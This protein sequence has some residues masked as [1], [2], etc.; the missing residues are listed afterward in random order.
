MANSPDT[1]LSGSN[2]D[3]IEG[4]YAR[5]LE[6]PSSV[7]PSWR[8]LFSGTRTEGRPL[9]GSGDGRAQPGNGR[10][11]RNGPAVAARAVNGGNGAAAAPARAQLVSV[12]DVPASSPRCSCSR[13]WTRRC[14]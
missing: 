12:G 5:W 11:A 7:D 1:F 10:G 14:T 13:G 9:L 8:E 3:F 2:I 6:D 4:L